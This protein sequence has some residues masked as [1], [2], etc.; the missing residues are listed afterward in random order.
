M[1]ANSMIVE[2]PPKTWTEQ[3][4]HDLY[5]ESGVTVVYVIKTPDEAFE[6][7]YFLDVVFM[8]RDDFMR[9]DGLQQFMRQNFE[10]VSYSLEMDFPHEVSKAVIKPKPQTISGPKEFIDEYLKKR[11]QVYPLPFDEV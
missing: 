6:I 5:T 10:L 1:E 7:S 4:I 8:S 11:N 9:L 2:L 3:E